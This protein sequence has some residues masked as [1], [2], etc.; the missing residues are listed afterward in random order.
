VKNGV[1]NGHCRKNCH[2]GDVQENDVSNGLK[3]ETTNGHG[4]TDKE[5]YPMYVL[6]N[7][8][9]ITIEFILFDLSLL[10]LYNII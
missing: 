5:R 1:E 8:E 10:H 6:F 7:F 9:P 3:K 2:L 4:S